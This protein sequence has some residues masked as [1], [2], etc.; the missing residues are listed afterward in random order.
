MKLGPLKKFIRSTIGRAHY[1]FGIVVAFPF[2]LSLRFCRNRKNVRVGELRSNVL[3]HF[4]FDAE[5]HL[6]KL[7]ARGEKGKTL[8]YYSHRTPVNTQ[9]DRMLRRVVSVNQSY[10]YLDW[11]SRVMS[12]SRDH[13]L[14]VTESSR[15]LEELIANHC[16]NLYF[17]E[18]EELRGLQFLR[19]IGFSELRGFV[20]VIVRDSAYKTQTSSRYH[21]NKDWS[22]HDYRNSSVDSYI[23]SV[24]YLIQQGYGVIR[25]GRVVEEK[26]EIHHE[27]FLDYPFFEGRNDFLDIWIAARCDFVVST[28]TGLDEVSRAFGRPAI[29]VNFLPLSMIVSYSKSVNAPKRLVWSVDNRELNLEECYE[30]SYKDSKS[31]QEARIVIEDLSPIEI[32]RVVEEGEKRFTNQW[33]DEPNDQR[34]QSMF[35]RKIKSLD[36]NQLLHG[37]IH[38]HTYIA[39]SF[40]ENKQWWLEDQEY[41]MERSTDQLRSSTRQE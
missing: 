5:F 3:G 20:L 30:C 2:A 18:E 11:A 37:K 29:N 40:I 19:D 12:Y 23:P 8:I 17:T 21:K 7:N 39:K 38:K 16:P 27:H 33:R 35:W 1:F 32:L 26:M 22:Y 41:R 15:D 14:F 6:A 13:T 34:L 25:G 36:P 31:Y 9:W 10:R 4:V 28:C 24:E